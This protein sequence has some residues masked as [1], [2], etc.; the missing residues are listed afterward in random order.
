MTLGSK[1]FEEQRA[2]RKR[3]EPGTLIRSRNY[4]NRVGG[5]E[6]RVIGR[7]RKVS[8]SNSGWVEAF[9]PEGH[10]SPEGEWRSGG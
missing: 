3:S 8:L 9:D 2:D 1:R 4:S 5:G 7:I 10:K 6:R